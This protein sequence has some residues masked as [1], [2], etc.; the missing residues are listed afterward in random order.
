MQRHATPWLPDLSS[1]VRYTG[2]HLHMY[3]CTILTVAYYVTVQY[4]VAHPPLTISLGILPSMLDFPFSPHGRTGTQTGLASHNHP[5]SSTLLIP[6]IS[7][8]PS[9]DS[10][11]QIPP[12]W[13]QVCFVSQI[14]WMSNLTPHHQLYSHPSVRE[15][16]LG[17]MHACN[18][19]T[20]ART[21]R[22]KIICSLEQH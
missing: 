1:R 18:A 3:I 19:R 10:P 20:R 15:Q 21:R 8:H 5:Q 7:T 2:T 12:A 16:K 4:V 9:L 22:I 11:R 13:F 14:R 17:F 6:P